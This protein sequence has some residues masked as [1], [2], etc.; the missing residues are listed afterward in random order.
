IKIDR[1]GAD[2]TVF[3]NIKNR[4]LLTQSLLKRTQMHCECDMKCPS[5]N[6]CMHEY[7][8]DCN[9]FQL[10]KNM[11]VHIHLAI[12]HH[13]LPVSET[14]Y[15]PHQDHSYFASSQPSINLLAFKLDHCY[16]QQAPEPENFQQSVP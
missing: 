5:C 6:E 4:R 12:I 7:S 10:S 2:K 14:P 3:D 15:H 16:A 9:D 11:C 1:T 13:K 8:C